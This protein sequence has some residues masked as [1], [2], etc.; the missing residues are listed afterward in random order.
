MMMATPSFQQRSSQATKAIGSSSRKVLAVVEEQQQQHLPL[1]QEDHQ[2]DHHQ[3]PTAVATSNTNTADCG[4]S[5]GSRGSTDTYANPPFLPNHMEQS[6]PTLAFAITQQGSTTRPLHD[7]KQPD[8]KKEHP[9]QKPLVYVNRAKRAACGTLITSTTSAAVTKE[10]ALAT[11]TSAAREASSTFYSTSSVSAEA[12]AEAR[13]HLRLSYIKS[14]ARELS[15]CG[16]TALPLAVMPAT[17]LQDPD[18]STS[19][20]TATPVTPHLQPSP[21]TQS[22]S[23]GQARKQTV[24][25]RFAR[26]PS[27]TSSATAASPS[28]T[29]AAAASGG[30]DVFGQP[31]AN[32]GVPHVYHDFSSVPDSSGYV[33]KK[34]GGVTQPFPEKLHE[35]LEKE[36]TEDFRENVHA[37]VG[38][39]P[40]GR[41]FLVRKPKEFTR[42]VMPK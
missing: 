8:E 37:T 5:D 3:S 29:G 4:R 17:T 1:L 23:D 27:P 36:S 9:Q 33:R 30:T 41:A 31:V 18:N 22:P 2:Q 15:A 13:R 10:S 6:K 20:A 39:L 40:H 21:L 19:E 35:L 24:T 12:E 42:D 34:T 32:R 7:P 26:E 28:A 25:T 14:A 16:Q 38:W 11:A